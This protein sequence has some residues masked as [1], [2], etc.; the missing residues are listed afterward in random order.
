MGL[1]LWWSS[2]CYFF[3]SLLSH[4]A[5]LPC[6]SVNFV[7][8]LV[9]PALITTLTTS[10]DSI[11]PSLSIQFS[12]LSFF[13]SAWLSVHSLQ[14]LV[15]IPGSTMS[16]NLSFPPLSFHF[17]IVNSVELVF[18][19]IIDSWLLFGFIEIETLATHYP[20][21]LNIDLLVNHTS[22]LTLK[23]TPHDFALVYATLGMTQSPNQ[24]FT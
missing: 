20:C 12:F 2:T 22:S 9:F 7:I 21:K 15:F 17:F 13:T 16:I 18:F 1:K 6:F 8:P 5:I 4:I 11:I 23:I 14:P 24:H 19:F 10:H 3:L